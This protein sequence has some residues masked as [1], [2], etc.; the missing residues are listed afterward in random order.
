MVRLDKIY[1]RGGDTGETSLTGGDRV[2]KSSEIIEA[3]G[4]I[5][6]TN[7]TIGLARSAGSPVRDDI[8]SR[9][10]HDLFDL[11]ADI[12]T[13]YPAEKALRITDAQVK[14]LENEIDELNAELSPLESFVLPGGLRIAAHL[15]VAR[16]TCRRAERAVVALKGKYDINPLAQKYI[17]RLS[18]LLFVLARYENNKGKADVLWKPGVNR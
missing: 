1:T 5:D 15:H 16:A 2:P 13:P 11:G 10:Q 4:A 7:S 17:N 14:R 6:E 12:S 9:I 3:I 18:D 8:L